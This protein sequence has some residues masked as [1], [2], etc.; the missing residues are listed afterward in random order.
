M[1]RAQARVRTRAQSGASLL[2]L[3]PILRMEES[4]PQGQRL[5]KDL[6]GQEPFVASEL[7]Q[8]PVG[9]WGGACRSPHPGKQWALT[10]GWPAAQD[11]QRR[12]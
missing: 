10:R 8:A 2:Q 9:G 12:A 1:P 4:G 11:W 5:K 6:S 7:A 3:T